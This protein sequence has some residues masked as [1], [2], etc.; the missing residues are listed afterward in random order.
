MRPFIL[1]AQRVRPWLRAAVVLYLLSC[2]LLV[3]VHQHHGATQSDECLLCTMAHTPAAI[4]PAALLPAAPILVGFVLR[5][6]EERNRGS[7]PPGTPKSRAPPH[8]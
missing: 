8:I 1:D 6:I 5:A 4:A 2:V 3:A 7:E